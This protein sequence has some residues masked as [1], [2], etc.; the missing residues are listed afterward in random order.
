MENPQDELRGCADV[1]RALALQAET[2]SVSPESLY[3]L[4][5]K[6]EE[7]AR[8]LDGERIERWVEIISDADGTEREVHTTRP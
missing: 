1:A 8:L 5:D 2:G 7:A 3:L 6:I 4:A